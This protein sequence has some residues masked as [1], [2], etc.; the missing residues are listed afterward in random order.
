LVAFMVEPQGQVIPLR[1]RDLGSQGGI[2]TERKTPAR[3]ESSG[4]PKVCQNA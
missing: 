1:S 3:R 2:A 4:W